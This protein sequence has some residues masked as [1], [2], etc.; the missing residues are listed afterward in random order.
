MPYYVWETNLVFTGF[1]FSHPLTLFI[2]A[3]GSLPDR[4]TLSA[5]DYA[6]LDPFYRAQA[7][8]QEPETWRQLKARGL[9]KIEWE[10]MDMQEICYKAGMKHKY[11]AFVKKCKKQ[12]AMEAK[13]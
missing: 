11:D 8:H 7:P 12:R 9:R 3:H 1:C 4:M 13:K 2:M 5:K 6:A 10:T